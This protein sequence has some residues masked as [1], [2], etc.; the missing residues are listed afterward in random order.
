MR[1]LWR[2]RGQA[3]VAV[4]SHGRGL[5]ASRRRRMNGTNAPM[6]V[7]WSRTLAL[8]GGVGDLPA[9]PRAPPTVSSLG[10]T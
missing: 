3:L 7:T 6:T 2:P 8:I 5:F 10:C 4:S 9:Y 1:Y